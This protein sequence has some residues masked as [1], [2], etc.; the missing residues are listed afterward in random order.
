MVLLLSFPATHALPERGLHSL[1]CLLWGS[2]HCTSDVRLGDVST[3]ATGV[4]E[5]LTMSHLSK[6]FKSLR[7]TEGLFFPRIH[8]LKPYP[9]S[10]MVFGGTAFG[11]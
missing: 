6:S 5:T 4:W 10:V 7:W 11:S 8:I 3:L 1:W 2:A 9:A